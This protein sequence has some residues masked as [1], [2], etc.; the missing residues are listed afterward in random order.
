MHRISLLFSTSVQGIIAMYVAVSFSRG[1][2]CKPTFGGAAWIR[3][4]TQCG[5]TRTYSHPSRS[6]SSRQRMGAGRNSTSSHRVPPRRQ[7]PQLPTHRGSLSPPL[8]AANARCDRGLSSLI[9][10]SCAR[11]PHGPLFQPRQC[12]PAVA[13]QAAGQG[14]SAVVVWGR[15]MRRSRRDHC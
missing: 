11:G 8:S 12:Q 3:R 1:S 5:T 6:R 10:V 13:G 15:M 9:R 14:P 2:R 7:E 4:H